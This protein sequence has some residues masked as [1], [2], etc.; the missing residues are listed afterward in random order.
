[1]GSVRGVVSGGRMCNAHAAF[2]TQLSATG[3]FE[4]LGSGP[5]VSP[6]FLISETSRPSIRLLYCVKYAVRV[7]DI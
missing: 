7:P 6:A 3:S 4:M 1:M 5:G 2:D